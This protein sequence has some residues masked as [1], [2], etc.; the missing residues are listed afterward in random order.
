MDPDPEKSDTEKPGPW[1]T[2]ETAGYRKIIRRPHNII[3]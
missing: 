2:W 3:Y 1:K